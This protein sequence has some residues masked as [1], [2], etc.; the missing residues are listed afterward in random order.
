MST[1]V[2]MRERKP[3]AMVMESGDRTEERRNGSNGERQTTRVPW[4]HLFILSRKGGSLA[5]RS[6]TAPAANFNLSDEI[7]GVHEMPA[8][9]ISALVPSVGSGP[10]GSRRT[11]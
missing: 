9:M 8:I 7:V 10:A 6:P 2:V 11:V 4:S 5:W 3:E 1:C